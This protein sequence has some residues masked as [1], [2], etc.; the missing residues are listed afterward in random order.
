MQFY[1]GSSFHSGVIGPHYNGDKYTFFYIDD[2][3]MLMLSKNGGPGQKHFY[4]K[5]FTL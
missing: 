4:V 5:L 2:V 3:I 1:A